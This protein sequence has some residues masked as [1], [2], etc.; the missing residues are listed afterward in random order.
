MLFWTVFYFLFYQ[1]AAEPSCD[2][3]PK[4]IKSREDCCNVPSQSNVMLEN[5]C[6]SRCKL[7]S[8]DLQDGCALECYVNMTTVI[9]EGTINKVAVKRIYENNAY[10]ER[11]WIKV[12]GEGVD[13]CEYN[14]TGSLTQN[15]I[16]FHTCVN[17]FLSD[18]CVSF[19]QT[20]EC[21]ASE[22][23]YEQCMNIQTTC[24][25]WPLHLMH[26]E[27]CCTIPQL[28]SDEFSSKC[29]HSCKRKE[30]F[31]LKQGECMNNCIFNETG[32]R[33]EEKIDF[34][35][36]ERMLIENSNKTVAWEKPI[37]DSVQICEK[38]VRGKYFQNTIGAT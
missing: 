27:S 21:D 25:S 17:N 6:F 28:F 19:V 22:V 36:V 7:K 15:L 14:S 32:L 5:V 35:V 26:P 38:S 16:K 24:T 9:K 37:K 3:W 10:E 18:N 2:P 12:I 11:Q 33:S 1:F 13:K 20:P 23:H 31:I 4:N 34:E 30:L 8:I 29:R